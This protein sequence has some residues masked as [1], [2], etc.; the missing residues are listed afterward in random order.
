MLALL[1][2]S[3]VVHFRFRHELLVRMFCE[4]NR[5]AVMQESFEFSGRTAMMGAIQQLS[6]TQSWQ[7]MD[8]I[9]APC[10]RREA[11]ARIVSTGNTNMDSFEDEVRTLTEPDKRWV[12]VN[13]ILTTRAAGIMRTEIKKIATEA[14]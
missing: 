9:L 10:P 14:V 13:T 2:I 3:T 11:W 1:I 4:E 7:W 12:W 6:E 8:D 5:V